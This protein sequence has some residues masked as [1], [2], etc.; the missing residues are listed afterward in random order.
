MNDKNELSFQGAFCYIYLMSKL[1]SVMKRV[2][3][4]VAVMLFLNATLFA[5]PKIQIT[6]DRENALYKI[7]ESVEFT[8]RCEDAGK[9]INSGG[10]V[11]TL[12][13]NGKNIV[14]SQKIDFTKTNPVKISGSLNAPGFL[15]AKA[16]DYHG[17]PKPKRYPLS[18]A[19]FEP[20]KIKMGGPLPKDFM[21]FWENGRTAIAGGKVRLKKIDSRSTGKYTSYAVTVDVLRGEKLYGFLVIPT[22]K[23][24]F[25]ACVHVPG[26][27]V[28]QSEPMT[29]WGERGVIALN[30]N[31]HKYPTVMD[32]SK[33]RELYAEQRKRMYYPIDQA[34]D[35][36]HYFFRNV[37]LG[38]DRMISYVAGL[39][40]WDRKHFV[41]DGSSQG[42]GMALI[43]AGFNKNITAAAANVPALCDHGGVYAGRQAGW[44]QL[45]NDSRPKAA[46][47]APYYDAAN[48]ARF[49]S[50]PVIVSVGFID[51]TCAPSSV[52][53]ACNQIKA[54]KKIFNMPC[55]GHAVIKPYT[56]MKDPWVEGQLGL[57][58]VIPPT[59]KQSAKNL[60]R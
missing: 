1:E 60:L 52:Y 36:D 8:V 26:A 45:I 46:E 42:G 20:E 5:A 44:P 34:E 59:Q 23:G 29:T 14:R 40:Q 4:S 50:C 7:G 25:P 33:M 21:K 31:V 15:Q 49:I 27:G 22:G 9:L 41:D 55:T 37:I 24:P 10:A 43:M 58:Q 56:D 11:V 35:R 53:A 51:T 57:R 6:T 19:G 47:V 12:I 48:F 18:G 3:L 32:A 2:L 54:P 13:R 17:I 16:G 39:P 30:M 28:G 38:V